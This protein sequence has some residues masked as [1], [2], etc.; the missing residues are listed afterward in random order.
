MGLMTLDEVRPPIEGNIGV[1][2]LTTSASAQ[3]DLG[4]DPVSTGRK[5]YLFV[6]DVRCYIT[7]SN[8]GISGSITT[9]NETAVS[10]DG[11]T[12]M[13]PA[14]VIMPIVVSPMN[15]YFIAKGSA[16]GYLRW[17]QG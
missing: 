2:A 6:S 12:F 7:F 16:S 1:V 8:D 14:D 9:P 10:G 4:L 11:R 5:S 17:Y 15:R 3:R 13:L